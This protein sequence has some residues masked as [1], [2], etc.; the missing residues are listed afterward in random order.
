MSGEPGDA[1][2]LAHEPVDDEMPLVWSGGEHV[3][4]SIRPISERP[5]VCLRDFG[6]VDTMGAQD[7][8][9]SA[10]RHRPVVTDRDS[11]AGTGHL[12]MLELHKSIT[13]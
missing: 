8:L 6:S 13:S 7:G 12:V 5:Q 2:G 3:S 4:Q 11:Y 9:V 10:H 1:A